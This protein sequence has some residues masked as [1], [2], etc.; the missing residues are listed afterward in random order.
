MSKSVLVEGH[1]LGLLLRRE[2]GRPLP[3][4][5]LREVFAPF[6][7]RVYSEVCPCGELC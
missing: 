1:A 5:E 3:W 2:G 7:G 4:L 6:W